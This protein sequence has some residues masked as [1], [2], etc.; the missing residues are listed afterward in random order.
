[1]YSFAHSHPCL[2]LIPLLMCLISNPLQL[3]IKVFQNLFQG[4][5]NWVTIIISILACTFLIIIRNVNARLTKF[6]YYKK[7]PVPIPSQLILVSW[8]SLLW[9]WR[10]YGVCVCVCVCVGVCVCVCVQ[11]CVCACVCACVLY[12]V[13]CIVGTLGCGRQT[14]GPVPSRVT[15]AVLRV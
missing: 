6:K 15:Q 12:I 8:D 13:S 4:N 7:F 11:A 9:A 3:W 1:M 10:C 14:I 2:S 5:V